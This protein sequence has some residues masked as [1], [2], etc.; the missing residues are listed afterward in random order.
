M[1]GTT[2]IVDI[3]NILKENDVFQ[4]KNLIQGDE[5]I[6]GTVKTD[7]RKVV[8]GDVFVAI[9]G[10]VTDGHFFVG[11][12]VKNGA[13]LIITEDLISCEVPQIKVTDSRKAAAL[14]INAVTDNPTSKLKLIGI[15]GTNGKTTTSFIIG[16]IFKQ[17]KIKYGIIGTLGFYIDDEFF[18]TKLTT[19][20]ILDL[21]NIFLKMISEKVEVVVM[22][23]SAHA[24]S[25]MRV[26]GLEFDVVCFT[27][28]SRDHLDFYQT[29]ENYFN[30]KRFFVESTASKG[31]KVLIN[32]EDEWGERLYQLV[33]GEKY[34]L[35]TINCDFCI[36]DEIMQSKSG[37]F[38]VSFSDKSVTMNLN[39]AG[40][41]NIR[42]AAM[43]LVAVKL[44]L[45]D[46]ACEAIDLSNLDFVPGRLERI[47]T[48]KGVIVF[49]DYAHTPDALKKVLE[50]INEFAK[51][52]IISISGAGGDRD[53]GKRPEMLDNALSKSDL[54]IITNDNPRYENPNAIIDD[55]IGTTSIDENFWIIRDRKLAIETAIKLAQKDDI[56]LIA[57]KG[58]EDYQEIGGIRHPFSDKEVALNYH[59]NDCQCGMLS[60]FIDLV[61]VKKL[62]EA[63][64]RN[65]EN[66][67]FKHV[68]TDS[69][70]IKS[71]TLFFALKG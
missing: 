18:P 52:R 33:R 62:L 25:L 42:N 53:K 5:I 22:E 20:D 19:P 50:N 29:M 8:Q 35:G 13:S 45:S 56:V 65:D 55:I 12:A 54:V 30:A 38:K 21:N 58:H 44:L 3:I 37:S 1:Q 28:L 24:V 36:S 31:G 17:L 59:E 57:G 49:I 66:Y 51:G 43:A 9:K 61:M 64:F 6:T 14:I 46:V 47:I 7:S 23:V 68:S 32:T 48:S 27:N 16:N 69:R 41:Y 2:K 71:N 70:K 34:S 60:V 63:D 40:R 26:C 15:T 39:L 10:F 4:S 67:V 11:T